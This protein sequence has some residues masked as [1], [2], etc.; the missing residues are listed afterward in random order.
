MKDNVTEIYPSG[1]GRPK[2]EQPAKKL[3]PKTWDG[4]DPDAVYPRSQDE[5]GHSTTC[6]TTIP[7]D[8]GGAGA[9]IVD[10]HPELKSLGDLMRTAYVHFL[11]SWSQKDDEEIAATLKGALNR[12]ESRQRA[13]RF[14]ASHKAVDD[15]KEILLRYEIDGEWG[16]IHQEIELAEEWAEEMPQSVQVRLGDLLKTFKPRMMRELG[17]D[18]GDGER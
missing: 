1:P 3:N 13:A 8:L 9:L 10:K 15:L 7:K 14:K 18:E 4:Y 17:L 16:M 2:R 11:Y 5:H 12:E 6:Q